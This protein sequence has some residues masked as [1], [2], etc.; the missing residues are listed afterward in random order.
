M[1]SLA[2][3]IAAALA[4][5]GTSRALEEIPLHE[6]ADSQGPKKIASKVAVGEAMKDLAMDISELDSLFGNHQ[7]IQQD[8]TKDSSG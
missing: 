7:A 6:L 3:A 2:I 8:A 5:A 1:A 4:G